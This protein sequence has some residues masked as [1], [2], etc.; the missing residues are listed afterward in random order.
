ML[1]QRRQLHLAMLENYAQEIK[2]ELAGKRD[3]EVGARALDC[4]PGT[5]AL[6]CDREGGF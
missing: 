6:H 4:Q 3:S 1:G 5:R 2:R